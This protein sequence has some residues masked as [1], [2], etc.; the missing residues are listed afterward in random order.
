VYNVPVRLSRNVT[1]DVQVAVVDVDA[2]EG[3]EAAVEAL[4]A[5][6]EMA[7]AE[8]PEETDTGIATETVDDTEDTSTADAGTAGVS[9]QGQY[10]DEMATSEV[11]AMSTETDA[12]DQTEDS[13]ES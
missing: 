11:A 4:L 13:A 2:P 1:T 10:S 3:V 7:E 6:P 12:A 5:A 8:E 9:E